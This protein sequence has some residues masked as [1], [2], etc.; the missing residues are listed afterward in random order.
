MKTFIKENKITLVVVGGSILL[1]ISISLISP[2]LTK[3]VL[4][5]EKKEY[6]VP[7]SGVELFET[8]Q[9][10]ISPDNKEDALS[11]SLSFPSSVV[12]ETKN[13]GR[14][15]NFYYDG[16]RVASF[17][18]KYQGSQGDTP[19]SYAKDVIGTRFP[20]AIDIKEVHFGKYAYI[21]AAAE[22]SYYRIG[23]F[24]KGDWIVSFEFLDG[25]TLFEKIILESLVVK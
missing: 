4:V 11:Y 6:R 14:T 20:V 23:S 12:R 2:P 10:A 18:F 1:Y 17:N 3:P 5:T 13:D 9:V 21:T 16:A 15:T 25:N 19:L 22:S 7:T 24:K 8:K